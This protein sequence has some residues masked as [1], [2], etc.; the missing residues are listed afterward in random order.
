MKEDLAKERERVQS[1]ELQVRREFLKLEGKLDRAKK[2]EVDR[3]L[4][5]GMLTDLWEY[6]GAT[7]QQQFDFLDQVV[8]REPSF[9]RFRPLMALWMNEEEKLKA[10]YAPR[11]QADKAMGGI[12]QKSFNSVKGRRQSLSFSNP[13]NNLS[14]GRRRQSMW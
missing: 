5:R 8:N 14:K 1:L 4:D 3:D 11:L 13:G 2:S 6:M 9:H 7:P 10:K 12:A